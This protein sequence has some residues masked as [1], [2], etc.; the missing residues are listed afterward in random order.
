MS[1]FKA[2]DTITH[3]EIDG[4]RIEV[5]DEVEC[6]Y[7]LITQAGEKFLRPVANVDDQFRLVRQAS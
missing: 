1:R 2:G 7:L 3:A 5:R 6:Q 4:P